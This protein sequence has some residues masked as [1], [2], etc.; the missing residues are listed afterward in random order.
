MALLL[1]LRAAYAFAGAGIIS[2]LPLLK[3]DLIIISVIYLAHGLGLIPA[4]IFSTGQG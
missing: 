4:S 2:P 1:F 3:P